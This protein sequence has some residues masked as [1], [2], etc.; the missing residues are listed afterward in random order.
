MGQA[1]TNQ[2]GEHFFQSKK[3]IKENDVIEILQKMYNYEFTKSQHKV[4]RK[5]VGMSQEALKFKQVQEI[6]GARLTE[7]YYEIP[8]SLRDENVRFPNNRSQAEKRFT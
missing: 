6:H 2:V 4:T 1:E 7:G 3:E 8:F 5:N